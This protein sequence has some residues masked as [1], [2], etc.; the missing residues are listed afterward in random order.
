M[1]SPFLSLKIIS[2]FIGYTESSDI[3]VMHERYRS[4]RS[5]CERHKVRL[6][7]GQSLRVSL[8]VSFSM[9]VLSCFMLSSTFESPY[10]LLSY[11]VASLA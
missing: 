4:V 2:D 6:S 8:S 10:V 3:R 5:V 1:R 11:P 9:L 7:L